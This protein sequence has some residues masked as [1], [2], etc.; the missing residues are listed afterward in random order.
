M[1]RTIT[2]RMADRFATISRA[3]VVGIA[4][5]RQVISGGGDVAA[6][7]S[8]QAQAQHAGRLGDRA[9]GLPTD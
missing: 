3:D 7:A 2:G 8:P 9:A 1:L 5:V 4:G 6:Q